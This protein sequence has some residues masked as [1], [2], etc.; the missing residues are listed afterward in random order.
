MPP[1]RF[2]I[3]DGYTDEPSGLGV[4]PYIDVYPRYAAGVVWEELGPHATVHYVTVDE[5]RLYKWMSRLPTYDVVIFIAG[6]TVPGKYLDGNPAT[7]E[8]LIRWA[9]II[10]G[11]FK[12]LAGP[13]AR[14]GLG[15]RGG[16][17]AYSPR[18]FQR[19]GFDVVVSGDIDVYLRQLI[20]DGQERAEHWRMRKSYAELGTAPVKG[21]RIVR[22][23]RRFGHGL[24]AE[25]ETYKGCAR[26]VSGGCSFCIEPLYGK[27]RSRSLND[28]IAE[29]EA[30]YSNG[31]ID[32]RI[33]RQ[34]DFYTI[35]SEKLGVDEWPRPNPDYVE[36][37]L[38]GIR[39]VAPGLRTLH[40]DNA[41]PG[42]L[43]RY[44]QESVRITKSLVRF[45]TPGDV[46][47]L[48]LETADP[49]VIK[50]NNLNTHPEE[51]L[52]AIKVI[53]RIGGFRDGNGVP[54]LLPGVNF[55]LGLPGETSETLELN[56]VFLEQILRENLLVR[57][58]NVRRLLVLPGTRV[59]RMK[60]KSRA[61]IMVKHR[62]FIRW[63]REH[64]DP[65]MFSRVFPAGTI[66]R[67][68][69]IESSRDDYSYG[70]PPGSYPPTIRMPRVLPRLSLVDVVVEGVASGRSLQ[71]RLLER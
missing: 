39:N 60:Y 24:V 59:S 57:R 42:T 20:K 26:W 62:S 38:R 43:V 54:H 67:N 27:P 30:L 56:K 41:N 18:D 51:S 22:M 37:L 36:R 1:N 66:I 47:A 10:D 55:V 31:V 63:V 29:V 48:G 4:P 9:R 21:A 3:V 53:N 15:E 49:R 19:A 7:P 8:E 23:H 2:L 28:I 11:P 69:Y 45:H 35:G 50:L 61:R 58:V 13:A 65:I 12:I 5:L 71:A 70:R 46:L 52:E 17:L 34:S 32:F 6:V 64:F 25:L 14:F 16:T 44:P 68:V 33:G 40:V